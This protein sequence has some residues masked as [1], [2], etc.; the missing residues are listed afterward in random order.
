MIQTAGRRFRPT[1]LLLFLAPVLAAVALFF[2]LDPGC[3]RPH[4]D[5]EGRIALLYTSD[6]GGAIDPCG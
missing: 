1:H 2:L 5:A 3:K 4:G 6:I